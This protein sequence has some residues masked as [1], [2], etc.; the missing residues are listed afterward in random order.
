MPDKVT[1]Q[2]GDK[3]FDLPVITGTENESAIEIGK[4]R[5]Q[6]GLITYDEGYKNTGVTQ[7]AITFLD[8]EL[9]ILRY[10][11]YN[12]EELA[13]KA[14]FVEVMYLVLYGELPTVEQ[15]SA[16]ENELTMHTLV[17]ENLVKVFEVFPSGCS[18]LVTFTQLKIS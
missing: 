11:G 9:G 10:R 17:H 8:G 15:L 7:S 4:L 3:S 13:G 2:Y 5:A 14:S 6:T 1:L 12:I 18:S 16:F